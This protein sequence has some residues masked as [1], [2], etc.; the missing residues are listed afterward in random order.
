MKN[1]HRR[2]DC[3]KRGNLRGGGGLARKR[4]GGGV[5][6]GGLIP[7]CTLCLSGLSIKDDICKCS[8][9]LFSQ[10]L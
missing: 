1:Q 10:Y 4:G 2:R 7:Q 8:S 3:L 6:Q 5:F 9:S